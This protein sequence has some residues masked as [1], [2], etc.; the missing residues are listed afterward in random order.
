[1]RSVL[2]PSS[3]GPRVALAT[4]AAALAAAGAACSGDDGSSVP[5]DAAV[6]APSIDAFVCTM[7]TCGGA[8][9]DG[10]IDE[11][12]CG[13]CNT[14]C[15]AGFSCQAGSCECPPSFVPAAPAFLQQQIRTDILPGATLGIGGMIESTINAMIVG[16]PT[17]NVQ[18]NHPD[19][20]SQGTPGT[21]PFMGV[22][23][24]LDLDTFTPSASFYATR[25][26]LTFT[27][28]CAA[29]FTG[30]LTA[31]HFVAVEG[32]MNPTLV[33]NGCAFDV[34]MIEFHYGDPC[35]TPE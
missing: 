12:H 30:T 7:I 33:E 19:D 29:G 24:D 15:E 18:V 16:Y 28:V 25:G 22:G 6:D 27:Q 1:M 35:P 31:A 26:T 11:M 3:R 14:S 34:P 23:Y 8:M 17:A 20:L 13:D 2:D 21:P 32:L 10:C 4:V 5:V 9:A